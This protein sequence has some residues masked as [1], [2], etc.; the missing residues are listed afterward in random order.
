MSS[1]CYINTCQKHQLVKHQ[2]QTLNGGH[3]KYIQIDS[4]RNNDPRHRFRNDHRRNQHTV[5]CLT[6]SASFADHSSA[7]K[8]P[9]LRAPPKKPGK[10][11]DT[12]Q[13]AY[14]R[15]LTSVNVAKTNGSNTFRSSWPKNGFKSMIKMMTEHSLKQRAHPTQKNEQPTR[16]NIGRSK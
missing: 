13:N 5:R 9:T 10:L 7:L 8:H 6:A 3:G 14:R 11:G 1:S 16:A 12:A 2:C 4:Y 15:T